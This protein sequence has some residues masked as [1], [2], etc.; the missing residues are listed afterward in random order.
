MPRR[1]WMMLHEPR[2]VTATMIGL[3]AV[4]VAI[5]LSA[6]LAPPMPIAHEMGPTLT[7]IWAVLLL[8]GGALGLAGCPTGWWWIERAGVILAGTGMTVY[9]AV[10]LS[11]DYSQPGSRLVQAGIVLLA[12][13]LLVTRWLRISGAQ[14]DP[15]RGL[16]RDDH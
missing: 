5:G 8:V 13:G 9:L 10:V 14:V 4:M 7:V 1:L 16:P 12:V 3:W 11:L 6:L 2:A 15:T